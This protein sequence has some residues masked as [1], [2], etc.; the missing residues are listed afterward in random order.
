LSSL[1]RLTAFD[2]G[3]C[4]SLDIFLCHNFNTPQLCTPEYNAP[5]DRSLKIF[6]GIS[7]HSKSKCFSESLL[8]AQRLQIRTTFDAVKVIRPIY[9]RGNVALDEEGRIL[10]SCLDE[11]VVLSDLRTGEELARIEGVSIFNVDF[12][13]KF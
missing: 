8:M 13:R 1:A 4:I 7:C 10:A 6:K 9:T 2:L 3:A 12:H 11:D 5:E